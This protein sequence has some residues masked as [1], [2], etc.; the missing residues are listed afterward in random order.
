MVSCFGRCLFL[1]HFV[2]HAL[3]P[4]SAHTKSPRY[5]CIYFVHRKS[6]VR[7]E[8]ATQSL[9]QLRHPVIKKLHV[10]LLR[11]MRQTKQVNDYVLLVIIMVIMIKFL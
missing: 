11:V 1:H 2:K 9:T 7:G 5:L 10:I 4:G 8:V 3:N 6:V